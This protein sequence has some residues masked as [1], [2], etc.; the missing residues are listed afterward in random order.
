MSTLTYSTA[1]KQ[2]TVAY[3]YTDAKGKVRTVSPKPRGL[4]SL[5]NQIIRATQRGAASPVGTVISQDLSGLE[6]VAS[7]SGANGGTF[8][9]IIIGFGGESSSHPSAALALREAV[10]LTKEYP[11]KDFRKAMRKRQI[12]LYFEPS[13]VGGGGGGAGPF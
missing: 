4:T 1:T 6:A 13:N 5:A 11:N 12:S 2:F 10:R 9:L 7:I 8:T 3:T